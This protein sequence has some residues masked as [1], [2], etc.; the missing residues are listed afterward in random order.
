MVIMLSIESICV[1]IMCGIFELK[2]VIVIVY[3]ESINI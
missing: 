3:S 2:I 1:I